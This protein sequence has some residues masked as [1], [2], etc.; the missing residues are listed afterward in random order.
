MTV[1][2]SHCYASH[3]QQVVALVEPFVVTETCA[4]RLR[5][6][7]AH[8][9]KQGVRRRAGE[10]WTVT[11]DDAREWVVDV[12]EELVQVWAESEGVID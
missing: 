12:S 3:L 9:D 7:I 10:E 11:S 2:P 5:A 4:L 6:L 1:I 8:E